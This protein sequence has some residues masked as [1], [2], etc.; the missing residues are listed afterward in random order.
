MVP[1]EIR[2]GQ[3]S[4]LQVMLGV[5]RLGTESAATI[6]NLISLTTIGFVSGS[7]VVSLYSYF[8]STNKSE[9]LKAN[10]VI[11][12]MSYQRDQFPRSVEYLNFLFK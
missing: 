2:A 1:V 6:L 7:L 3:T 4:S 10:A 5:N 12:E 11:S 9:L 8:N